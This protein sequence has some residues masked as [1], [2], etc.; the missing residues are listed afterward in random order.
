MNETKYR[1]VNEGH[2]EKHAFSPLRIE[3][4]T[5][6]MR[7]ICYC[8]YTHILEIGIGKGLLKYFLKPFSSISHTSIDR[9]ARLNPDY[10]GSVE[11]MPFAPGEFEFTICCQVLEHLP[12]NRIDGA[13]REIRR[14]TS[15]KVLL[16]L[17]DVR[18]RFGIGLCWRRRWEKFE[19]NI[20]R[21]LGIK[22]FNGEHC[23]EIG[24][25]GTRARMVEAKIR[26]AGFTIEKK[27]RL[28]EHKWHSYFLLRI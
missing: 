18:W 20:E 3:S 4:I 26:A 16:S 28:E 6:Q 14:V 19:F 11:K 2:Y 24:Y 17:P 5:E 1:Q 22:A 9:D 12:F 27:W 23:W 25:P 13:L 21:P 7:Q 15:E 10:I 8:G